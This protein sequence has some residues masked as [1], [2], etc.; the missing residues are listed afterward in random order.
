MYIP[1]GRELQ[2][3]VSKTNIQEFSSNRFIFS[4]LYKKERKEILTK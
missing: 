4:L 1:G 2:V 3:W